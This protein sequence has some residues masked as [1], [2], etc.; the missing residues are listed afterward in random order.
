MLSISSR[1]PG[2]LPTWG[3]TRDL[4]LR[5][6]AEHSGLTFINSAHGFGS[7]PRRAKTTEGD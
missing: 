6:K 1:I 4:V 2:S 3:G 7:N 5:L